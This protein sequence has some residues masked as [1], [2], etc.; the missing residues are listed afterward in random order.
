[1]LIDNIL[2]M[3]K[4]EPVNAP[5]G[6]EFSLQTALKG[7]QAVEPPGMLAQL[8]CAGEPGPGVEA[9]HVAVG[10]GPMGDQLERIRQAIDGGLID[11]PLSHFVIAHDPNHFD[12]RPDDLARFLEDL[13]GDVI[14]RDAVVGIHGPDMTYYRSELQEAADATGLTIVVDAPGVGATIYRPDVEPEFNLDAGVHAD[15]VFARC[16]VPAYI[17]MGN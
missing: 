7:V 12:Q 3:S 4:S 6:E 10:W 2:S 14:A 1:M 15:G 13:K 8:T 5:G 9:H 11:G 16:Q 17:D